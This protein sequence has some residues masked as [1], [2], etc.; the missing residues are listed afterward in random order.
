VYGLCYYTYFPEWYPAALPLSI[1]ISVVSTA[2][3]L[4]DLLAIRPQRQAQQVP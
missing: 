4:I 3:M 1:G 2:W